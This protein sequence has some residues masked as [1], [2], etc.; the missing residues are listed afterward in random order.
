MGESADN[1]SA[2]GAGEACDCADVAAYLD[3]ELGVAEGE[4]FERH[5]A[6]CQA[7]SAAL[8]EQRRLLCLLDAAFARA[9]KKVELPEDFVRVVKARA[10]TD[11]TCVRRAS[12]RRLAAL[13]VA[14]L[15]LVACA[16]LGARFASAG[17]A[18]LRAAAGAALSVADMI[19]HTLAETAAGLLFILRGVGRLLA[20]EPRGGGAL[21]FLLLA[22]ALAALLRLVSDYHRERLPD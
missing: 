22:C 8:A 2:G 21:V 6:S 15:A 11:M 12:E 3:G 1:L 19:L 7:C 16:L 17:L 14:A 20:T 18:P 5:V 9:Q 13:V 10:Q 4:A